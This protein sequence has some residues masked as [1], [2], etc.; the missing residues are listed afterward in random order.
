[1]RIGNLGFS[2]QTS[3]R[4]ALAVLDKPVVNWRFG[5]RRRRAPQ[6]QVDLNVCLVR[7][8]LDR[9]A[10][11]AARKVAV[12]VD[13]VIVRLPSLIS[14]Q[15]ETGDEAT[16]EDFSL[17]ID[18]GDFLHDQEATL[19]VHKITLVAETFEVGVTTEQCV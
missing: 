9:N 18:V 11:C 17:R 3:L 15:R 6:A 10:I 16:R 12:E 8:G 14:S 2:D 1:M 19:H 7:N 13:Y 4:S 5:T